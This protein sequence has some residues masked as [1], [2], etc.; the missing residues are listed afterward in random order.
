[1]CPDGGF[2]GGECGS[3]E[4]VSV[5]ERVVVHAA[6]VNVPVVISATDLAVAI[7]DDRPADGAAVVPY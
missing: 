4:P 1:V 5:G 3:V 6:S 7:A 2:R